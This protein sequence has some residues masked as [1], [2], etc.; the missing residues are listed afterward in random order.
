MNSQD[1]LSFTVQKRFL[2]PEI[3]LL[4]LIG[5]IFIFSWFPAI[6]SILAYGALIQSALRAATYLNATAI[7]L[8]LLYH[9]VKKELRKI[10]VVFMD[11]RLIL[12]TAYK[13]T[14]IR[15]SEITNLRYKKIPFLKGLITV[16]AKD[17][18]IAVPLCIENCKEFTSTLMN[19]LTDL[20]KTDVFD[21]N[22]NRLLLEDVTVFQNS[23]NRL[24]PAFYP[25][26]GISIS[27]FFVNILIASIIW[28]LALIPLLLWSITGAYFPVIAYAIA[29][30]N[31]NRKIKLT[32]KE[33][34]ADD[35]SVE[36]LFSGLLIFT[37][38]L[39]TGIFFKAFFLWQ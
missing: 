33:N 16:I 30:W 37:L 2:Y 23:Y 17:A 11:E 7:A 28:N 38:Y 36:Y 10:E 13:V 3:I 9:F 1:R 6:F 27:I 8:L 34:Y 5:V 35:F 21:M 20:N 4:S 29:D 19:V 24:K 14:T 22:S 25:L 18:S 15:I 31:I 12:K 39:I 32:G 26:I